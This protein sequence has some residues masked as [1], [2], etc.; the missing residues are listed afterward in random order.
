MEKFIFE[1]EYK[2]EET[3]YNTGNSVVYKVKNNKDNGISLVKTIKKRKKHADSRIKRDYHIPKLINS[4]RIIKPIDFRLDK[5]KYYLF[6]PFL[7]N[8]KTLNKLNYPNLDFEYSKKLV[9]DIACVI[10]EIHES[11]VVHRDIKPQ[12]ILMHE[13]KIY[14]IDFDL[15]C[16]LENEKFSIQN[17]CAGTPF[18]MAPEL[19]KRGEKILDYKMTDIYSF[20]I[21]IYYIFNKKKLP[22]K[23]KL[24]QGQLEH[25]IF[26]KE[27]R[28]SN[29][30]NKLVDNFI[31]KIIDNDPKNRPSIDEIILF[32]QPEK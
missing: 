19:W 12:N 24:S 17:T 1:S 23:K 30:G 27:A 10:K 26:N 20:G 8:A 32:F 22:Y 15:S 3:I 5:E 14:V 28:K 13:D 11:N 16:S 31:M 21:T 9:Y 18:Y 2:I 7:E 29:C 25:A 6:Y 4:D